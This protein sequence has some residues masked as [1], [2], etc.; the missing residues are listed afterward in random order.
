MPQINKED[1]ETLR[2]TI[3]QLWQTRD[4]RCTHW[5]PTHEALVAMQRLADALTTE[6]PPNQ[7]PV[8]ERSEN[9]GR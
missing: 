2:L 5:R 9:D 8:T 3:H 7:T 1:I 6:A 4:S